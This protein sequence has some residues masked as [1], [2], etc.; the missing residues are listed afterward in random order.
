MPDTNATQEEVSRILREWS[1]IHFFEALLVLAVGL[2]L[3]LAIK[4]IVPRIARRLPDRFRFWVLPW[5]PILRMVVL[6]VVLAYVVPLFIH[7]TPE[8][9]LAVSGALAVALGFAFKDYAS[10][11]I[12]GAVALYERPYR[13]GDW[14]KI[15]DTYGEVRSLDLRTVQ[16]L[17]PDDTMVA[18]PHN[19]I[20]TTAIYNDNSGKRDLMC[21][22]DFYL[23]PDHDGKEI[24]QKLYDVALASPYLRIQKPA[25]VVA[26]EKPWGTHYRLKA[27]P[28][29][30]RDQFLFVTDLT[31]RGKAMLRRLGVE[32]AVTPAIV[33]PSD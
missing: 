23:H 10:S 1:E 16:I 6:L 22:A 13:N 19:K 11:L 8:N 4:W 33:Q 7:P 17:T 14:V 32:P 29:D 27:Y 2:A 20:W 9:L 12:A 24:R 30:G 3:A 25:V 26:T 5:E 21:V 18:V 31:L 28:I 15:D